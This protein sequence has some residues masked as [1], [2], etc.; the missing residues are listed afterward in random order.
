MKKKLFLCLFIFISAYSMFSAEI[1]DIMTIPFGTSY[2]AAEKIILSKN[3]KKVID[4][5]SYETY[6]GAYKVVTYE[7]GSFAGKTNVTMNVHFF[8]DKMFRIDAC[9]IGWDTWET[10]LEA[11]VSK[12]SLKNNK[13]DKKI[14]YDEKD[15]FVLL[16]NGY[17]QYGIRIVNMEIRNQAYA[18]AD[19]YENEMER[20]KKEEQQRSKNA[21]INSIKEEI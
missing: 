8:K 5:E 11:Y 7:N 17:R 15:N 12:Y 18:Y 10:V 13:S 19:D 4:D 2:E 3:F 14:F 16:I 6:G 20:K 1:K 9:T 21:E